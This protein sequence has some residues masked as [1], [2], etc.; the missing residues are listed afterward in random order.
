[1]KILLCLAIVVFHAA[2]G[3]QNAGNHSISHLNYAD[4]PLG[5]FQYDIIK[6]E[7]ITNEILRQKH[8]ALTY[9]RFP[10]NSLGLNKF[11]KNLFTPL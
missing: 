8:Q 10:Y 5:V 3:Q 4:T 11:K 9:F 1:M 6:G 2:N 7:A